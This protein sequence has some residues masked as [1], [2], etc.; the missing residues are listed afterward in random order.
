MSRHQVPLLRLHDSVELSR[1]YLR[2]SLHV[3]RSTSYHDADVKQTGELSNT[4]GRTTAEE[5]QRERSPLE[6]PSS[7]IPSP[8]ADDTSNQATHLQLPHLAQCSSRGPPSV[9]LLPPYSNG[10]R[11]GR[12]LPRSNARSRR[13]SW[14]KQSLIP[15]IYTFSKSG[16]SKT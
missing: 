13:H 5:A 3:T 10:R 8:P 1:Y 2:L 11:P 14:N 4:A 9:R 7:E 16:C 6:R 15:R 12:Q